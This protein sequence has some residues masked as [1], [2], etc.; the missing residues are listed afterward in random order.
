MWYRVEDRMIIKVCFLPL[1]SLQARMRPVIKP[2]I[3]AKWIQC[4]YEVNIVNGGDE[5]CYELNV[6]PKW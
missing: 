5:G 3:K 4:N 6:S 1:K 2:Q